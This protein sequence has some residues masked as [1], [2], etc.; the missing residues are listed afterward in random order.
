MRLLL[1][2]LVLLELLVLLVQGV[3]L[4]LLVLLVLVVLV[5]LLVLLLVLLVVVMPRALPRFDLCSGWQGICPWKRAS[6]SE[7][8]RRGSC[9]LCS[10]KSLTR[11][12]GIRRGQDLTSALTRLKDLSTVDFTSALERLDASHRMPDARAAPDNHVWWAREQTFG[13]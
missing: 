10:A 4:V 2:L 6:G 12:L 11:E 7:L 13:L 8:N 3:L 5:V 1:H 9:P